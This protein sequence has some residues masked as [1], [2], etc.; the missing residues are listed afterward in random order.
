MGSAPRREH[1]DAR[2]VA[3]SC[4]FWHSFG[5][6]RDAVGYYDRPF[7]GA[8]FVRTFVCEKHARQAERETYRV[9]RNGGVWP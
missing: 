6:K 7:D 3:E 8:S 1:E 9:V 4:G 2:G 5:R